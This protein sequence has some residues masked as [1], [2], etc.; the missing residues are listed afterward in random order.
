VRRP[1]SQ[2]LAFEAADQF[3]GKMLRV[4]C[5]TAIAARKNTVAVGKRGKHRVDC[6][7]NRHRQ[8]FQSFEFDCRAIAEVLLNAFD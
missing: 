2:P 7:G 3:S 4:R 5:G 6:C 8:G 1:A